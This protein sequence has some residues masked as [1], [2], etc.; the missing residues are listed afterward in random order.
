MPMP[1][2]IG[3]NP[4]FYQQW[5]VEDF[6]NGL[7]AKSLQRQRILSAWTPVHYGFSSCLSGTQIQMTSSRSSTS[8]G[9]TGSVYPTL[10][11]FPESR[12]RRRLGRHW[13][14]ATKCKPRRNGA[15]AWDWL[16]L[17]ATWLIF[18]IILLCCVFLSYCCILI[19]H[20][21]CSRTI[22]HWLVFLTP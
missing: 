14:V 8:V 12:R 9:S 17:L 3:E 18:Y 6:Q 5:T 10:E 2:E 20:C 7:C 22:F 11:C 13:F 4:Q 15:L 21:L 16:V 1:T 19:W